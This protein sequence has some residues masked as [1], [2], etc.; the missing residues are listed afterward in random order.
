MKV[1]HTHNLIPALP[2]ND[3]T[4]GKIYDV[5][6]STTTCYQIIDDN[7]NENQYLKGRFIDI[8]KLRKDKL[9]RILK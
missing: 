6:R 7:G 5:K 2:G 1:V 8:T 9:E 4:V 3:L